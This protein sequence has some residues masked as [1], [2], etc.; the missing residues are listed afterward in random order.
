LLFGLADSFEF[1]AEAATVSKTV[2]PSGVR[3]LSEYVPSAPSVAIAFTVGV[4]SRDETGGHFGSTHFLEH[5]LFKGT[6][7]RSSQDI[8]EAFD[9]VGGSSNAATSKEYTSYYARVQNSALPLAVDVLADMFFHARIDEPDFL[10][11]RT[12]ILEELAMNADDPEDVAHEALAEALLPGHELGRP[13]GGTPE[14]IQAVGREAVWQHYREHYQPSRLIVTAAGGVD[15]R[16]L[17][18]LVSRALE[19]DG[20]A[21]DTPAPRR[22]F[23]LAQLPSVYP[24]P[25]PFVSVTKQVAQ[26]NVLL[27]RPSIAA[28]DDA[29]FAYGVLNTVLGGGMSSRLYQKIRE[30]RGLAYSTYSYQHPYSETGYFGMYAGCA[31]ENAAEVV[32]LMRGELE[33]LAET[34][35]T[36]R[37]LELARGNI[38]GSLA[39]RFESS[40]AR[41]NRLLATELGTG[42]FLSLAE[43]IERYHEVSG[44]A[45][46]AAAETLARAK[47]SLVAVGAESLKDLQPLA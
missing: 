8:S 13:I 17:V 45:V 37:E 34:G 20:F 4:G 40:M 10:T 31:P 19:I 16:E 30:Q 33:A 14:T 21:G 42:E 15:H 35:P 23:N 2:L 18:S 47:G 25:L 39:L 41:M 44:E 29:R 26:A 7:A 32:K 3:I 27:G 6:A 12:V 1:T 36:E 46:R 5:L 22:I 38:S 9:S 24:E 11:E 28:G 43:M